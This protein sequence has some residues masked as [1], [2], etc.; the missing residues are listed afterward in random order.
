MVS[1][2]GQGGLPRK[3]PKT[4]P[5]RRAHGG[6]RVVRR[7]PH[8][9]VIALPRAWNEHG[10]PLVEPDLKHGVR[11]SIHHRC[12]SLHL[13]RLA[14]F[15]AAVRHRNRAIRF[16]SILGGGFDAAALEE[17]WQPR[18]LVPF[19]H[20]TWYFDFWNGGERFHRIGSARAQK[21]GGGEAD[22]LMECDAHPPIISVH[23]ALY[24]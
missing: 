14:G 16:E 7:E 13:L 24:P 17:H 18:H 9:E 10:E 6:G 3:Y 5:V 4:L 15:H 22:G 12:G 20:V 11:F 19:A 8:D 1:R 21:H 23:S 2:S